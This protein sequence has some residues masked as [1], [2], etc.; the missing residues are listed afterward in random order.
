MSEFFYGW[1]KYALFG[2]ELKAS[3]NIRQ[4][5]GGI[6]LT[7]EEAAAYDAPFP[8]EIFMTGICTLPSMGSLIDQEKSLAAWEALKQFEKPFLT[9]FG[10]YDMLVGSE[11]TQN[12]LI[13][14][15]PG[16]KGLPHDRIP[17][18]HFIQ[19]SQGEEMAKRLINFISGN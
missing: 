17:T 4:D 1:M 19:E 2:P 11:K 3:D 7:D 5:F 13:D 8:D 15:I 16:A 10:Q 14:N 12:T 9:V 6:E 18:G